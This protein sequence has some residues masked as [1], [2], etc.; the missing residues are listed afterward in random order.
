M[1]HLTTLM[2]SLNQQAILLNLCMVPNWM[3]LIFFR[4]HCLEKSKFICFIKFLSNFRRH[5]ESYK[6]VQWIIRLC[7]IWC[8]SLFYHLLFS[9][10]LALAGLSVPWSC[11]PHMASVKVIY[12]MALK[13]AAVMPRAAPPIFTQPSDPIAWVPLTHIWYIS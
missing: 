11:M 2:I 8:F 9:Y 12:W 5:L 10:I 1:D 3:I 6:Y 7:S 13:Y 4:W